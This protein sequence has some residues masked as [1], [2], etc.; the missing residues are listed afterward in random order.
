M[1]NSV[2]ALGRTLRRERIH[3][4]LRLDDVALRTGL[5]VGAL[6]ALEAGTVA[7]IPDRV[8]ILKILRRYA[9]FV[10]LPGDRYAL[11][12]IDH[13]P[14]DGSPIVPVGAAAQTGSVAAA[15]AAVAAPSVTRAA[16]TTTI[17]G[18]G[19]PPTDNGH[20]LTAPVAGLTSGEVQVGPGPADAM[21]TGA[22]A[23]VSADAA[24]LQGAAPPTG[25][26]T[27]P[28]RRTFLDPTTAPVAM[29]LADTG[30]SSAIPRERP[31][32]PS[33]PRRPLFWL[34]TVVIV[35][36]ILVLVGAAGL[37][38]NHYRPEWIHKLG[39]TSA[40]VTSPPSHTTGGTAPTPT[41]KTPPP[42][43]TQSSASAAAATYD[44]HAGSF[45]VGVVATGG[46]SWVQVTNADNG[47][48]AFAG[49]LNPGERKVFNVDHSLTLQIGSRAGHVYV[50]VDKKL[51]SV[52]VPQV[53]PFLITYQSAT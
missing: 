40:P 7:H 48:P 23:A 18:S 49:V 27:D 6:E 10:G 33:K 22:M 32:R 14:A 50:A 2:P 13:W 47:S 39:I 52:F 1:P 21:V 31:P 51:V 29:V 26:V 34:R 41:G 44:V 36:A 28:S 53:A 42:T 24:L 43:V 8:L 16:P 35:V 11:I 46:P 3:L 9:D 5:P 45:Q 38:V 4:G 17:A 25:V 12:L 37:I 19:P 15:P 20:A 30:V